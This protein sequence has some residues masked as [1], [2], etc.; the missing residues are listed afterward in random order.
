MLDPR[1]MKVYLRLELQSWIDEAHVY[2]SPS[3]V[4]A[5]DDC[6]EITN[7]ISAMH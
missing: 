2:R 1:C 3:W 7:V 6:C 4:Q 5:D